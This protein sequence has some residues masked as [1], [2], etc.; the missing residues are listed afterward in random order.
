MQSVVTGQAQITSICGHNGCAYS[1]VRSLN[2]T[3]FEA[4]QITSS[5]TRDR[6]RT[7]W[8]VSGEAENLEVVLP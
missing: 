6:R 7:H 2:T 1:D 4:P 3:I 8:H 5:L